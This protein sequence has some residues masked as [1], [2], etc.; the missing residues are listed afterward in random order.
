M[1]PSMDPHHQLGAV[2]ILDLANLQIYGLGFQLS[3]TGS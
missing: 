2:N 3:N 1:S